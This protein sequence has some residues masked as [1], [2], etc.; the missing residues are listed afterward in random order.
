MMDGSNPELP[1]ERSLGIAAAAVKVPRNGFPASKEKFLRRRRRLATIFSAPLTG[2]DEE[3]SEPVA[4]L[5]AKTSTEDCA[6]QV[7]VR[8]KN[9]LTPAT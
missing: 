3:E 1:S 9:E 5:E 8:K 4:D 7:Q 6:G 2:I